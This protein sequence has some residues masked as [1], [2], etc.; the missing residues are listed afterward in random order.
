MDERTCGHLF[1]DP[2]QSVEPLEFDS[3]PEEKFYGSFANAGTGWSI[4]REPEPL[5]A[6]K[7][8]YIPDFL[9]EKDG[10]KVYVEIAGFW[11]AE[12]LKRKA[13]KLRELKGVNLLVLASTKMSCDAFKGI[14]GD[15]ILFDRKVPLKEVLDRLKAW[16]EKKIAGDVDRL[17]ERGLTLEGDVIRVEDIAAASGV[18]AD[19]VRRYLEENGAEGYALMGDELVSAEVLADIERSLPRTMPYAEASALIRSKGV[20]AVDP[21]LKLLGYTVKWSGL[22]PE[23]AVI[24]RAERKA[25]T[26]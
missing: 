10:I 5:V 21:A 4:M 19:A 6:G 26:S 22:D 7:Y 9:L 3:E 11:T 13:S 12:Y 25:A 16:D 23:S 20:G 1:G 14:A 8:L 24:Y 18:P 17:K 15:A 2:A